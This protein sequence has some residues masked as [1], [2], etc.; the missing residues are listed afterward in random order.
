MTHN[1]FSLDRSILGRL[2]ACR[3]LWLLAA[4]LMGGLG[5]GWSAQPASADGQLAR[6]IRAAA[7]CVQRSRINGAPGYGCID[8][9]AR[10]CLNATQQTTADMHMC[11]NRSISAWDALLNQNYQ[12]VMQGWQASGQSEPRDMLRNAQRAWINFRDDACDAEA[13]LYQGG[14]LHGVIV[15]ACLERQTALRAIDL[16]NLAKDQ[17]R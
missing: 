8:T 15:G 1:Q 16:I 10:P 17:N 9:I 7:E 3:P 2:M 12:A 11:M 5:S 6:D 4:A 13:H 14:T